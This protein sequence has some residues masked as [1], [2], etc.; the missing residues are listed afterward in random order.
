MH[1]AKISQHSPDEVLQRD[2]QKSLVDERELERSRSN[3]IIGMKAS[4]LLLDMTRLP[5]DILGHSKRQKP[6]EKRT[7]LESP[8]EG[9]RGRDEDTEI[10]TEYRGVAW[11]VNKTS[12][13]TGYEGSSI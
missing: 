13:E 10:E 2:L 3:V 8:T 11:D 5:Y 12:R 6:P 1:S 9:H 4:K 7:F